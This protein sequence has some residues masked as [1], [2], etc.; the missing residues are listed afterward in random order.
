MLSSVKTRALSNYQIEMTKIRAQ[1]PSFLSIETLSESCDSQFSCETMTSSL[2]SQIPPERVG[3]TG[4][5]DHSGL[6]KRVLQAF[7]AEFSPDD[8][9]NVRVTQR[10]KVVVLLGNVADDHMLTRLVWIALRVEG[11]IGVETTGVRLK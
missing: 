9:E 8:L 1:V 5:Y 3:L 6:A 2:L 11:T 7:Q 4:E 10:G